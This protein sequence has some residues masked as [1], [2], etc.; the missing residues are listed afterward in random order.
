MSEWNEPGTYEGT[1]IEAKWPKLGPS[2][3][4][5]NTRIG[6]A[7]DFWNRYEEDIQLAKDIGRFEDVSLRYLAHPST[8]GNGTDCS[9]LKHLSPVSTSFHGNDKSRSTW[10]QK[11]SAPHGPSHFA[12]Q[13]NNGHTHHIT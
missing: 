13:Q 3:I 5:K 1:L 10:P 9:G 8:R 4:V 7:S 2:K 12:E 6:V 11:F